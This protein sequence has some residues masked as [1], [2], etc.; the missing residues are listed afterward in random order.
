MTDLAATKRRRP[1]PKEHPHWPAKYRFLTAPEIA[2][3]E[4]VSQRTVVTWAKKGWPAR[5]R[6][7]DRDPGVRG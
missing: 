1:R 3:I 2:E 7:P 5:S 6:D 4:G